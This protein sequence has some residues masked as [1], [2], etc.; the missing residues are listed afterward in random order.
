[1]RV[2]TRLAGAM[3]LLLLLAAAGPPAGHG[4]KQTTQPHERLA[5]R[6]AAA[7]AEPGYVQTRKVGAFVQAIALPD[8][9][10]AVS[11]AVALAAL[12]G[13]LL[14]RRL[15][16]DVSATRKTKAELVQEVEERRRIFETS[17]D[18]IL[19]TD[20]EGRLLHVS[21]SAVTILGYHPDEL[22][23]RCADDVILGDDRPHFRTEM[24]AARGSGAMRKF[25]GRCVH[26]NGQVVTLTWTG[27]WSK[28]VQ[29]HF[30]SGRDITEHELAEEKFRLAVEASPSGI[31][32]T[33]RNGKIVLVN[34]EAERMFAY[35]REEL[36]DRPVD[37]LVPVAL[38]DCHSTHRFTFMAH[39]AARRLGPS[40][41]LIALRKD[42][43]EFPVEIGLNPIRTPHGL[44]VLSTIVDITAS[45]R[46]REALED[47]ERMARGIIDNA[48]DAFVQMDEAGRIIDWNPHAVELFG[49][50]RADA[51]DRELG[52]LIV[53][54][55]DRR[56]YGRGH[57][58]V[59][60]ERRARDARQALRDRRAAARRQG[61][62]GRAQRR[63]AAPARPLRFFFE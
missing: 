50:S 29:K 21:P 15:T 20:P 16:R 59:H 58:A 39:P 26:K 36:L 47:S 40:R 44:F 2:S 25:D 38:R 45:R 32:M 18:L 8:S 48:L 61:D 35:P 5:A 42:G 53:S 24:R 41:E 12:L 55:Q 34:S 11:A 1:M 19:V 54:E 63:G 27:A 60:T 28:P 31:V 3:V 30:L 22:V 62:S 23:G 7:P 9:L 43:S 6:S 4:A 33:D 57:G 13:W 49:W 52:E 17:L 37:T 14:G 46:A 10:V 51:V 56:R